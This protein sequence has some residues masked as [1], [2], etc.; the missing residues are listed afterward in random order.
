MEQ[1][2]EG[3]A[4]EGGDIRRSERA[5][6]YATLFSFLSHP[7]D[8]KGRERGKASACAAK[9]STHTQIFPSD[10]HVR[11]TTNTAFSTW[12]RAFRTET[13]IHGHL[14]CQQSK[15]EIS[16]LPSLRGCLVKEFS[17]LLAEQPNYVVPSYQQR[18]L[19]A[20][21]FICAEHPR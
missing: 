8:T 4:T 2:L 10:I 17:S 19:G 12:H 16:Y 14:N 18:L 21:G 9:R 7:H 20:R 3:A 5:N 11:T 13:A 15:E 6:R 1:E